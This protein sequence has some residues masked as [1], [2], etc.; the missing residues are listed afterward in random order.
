MNEPAVFRPCSFE[1]QVCGLQG[2]SAGGG[3]RVEGTGSGTERARPSGEPR[4]ASVPSEHPFPYAVSYK[5]V[6]LRKNV[7]VD[8]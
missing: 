3:L 4:W 5:T 8:K 6:V 7:F 2:L 1:S